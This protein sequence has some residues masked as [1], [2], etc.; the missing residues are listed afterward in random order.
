MQDNLIDE[1]WLLVNPILLGTGVPLFEK[2]PERVALQL[3][4]SNT[5]A[6]GVIASHYVKA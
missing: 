6:S 4:E 2:I 1:Y 3:V 5:L